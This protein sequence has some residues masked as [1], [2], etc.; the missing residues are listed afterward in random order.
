MA[1]Y[2]IYLL[3]AIF[4][5]IGSAN[6]VPIQIAKHPYF[7][8][9]AVGYS[10]GG[11]SIV[12]LSQSVDTELKS[13]V[14]SPNQVISLKWSSVQYEDILVLS[15][16]NVIKAIRFDNLDSFNPSAMISLRHSLPIS[17]VGW[18][19]FGGESI[20]VGTSFGFV[21]QYSFSFETTAGNA[22]YWIHPESD[23]VHRWFTGCKVNFVYQ[24]S[25]GS[26]IAGCEEGVVWFISATNA[27][28][29]S[30]IEFP[31]YSDYPSPKV[32][33]REARGYVVA[34]V[35]DVIYLIDVVN[36]ISVL[37]F[38]IQRKVGSST[39]TIGDSKILSMDV[40]FATDSE[41]DTL[42]I[43]TSDGVIIYDIEGLRSGIIP[44][45]VWHNSTSLADLETLGAEI[46]YISV[47][48]GDVTNTPSVTVNGTVLDVTACRNDK[49]L[50]A[51]NQEKSEITCGPDPPIVEIDIT[52]PFSVEYIE[53][54]L[55]L[56]SLG[57]IPA[58]DCT[59]LK[60]PITEWSKNQ[61]SQ[62]TRV[63]PSTRGQRN[64]AS[65][66]VISDTPVSD[67]LLTVDHCKAAC[68]LRPEC[69]MI[70]VRLSPDSGLLEVCSFHRCE[71]PEVAPMVST[72]FAEIWTLTTNMRIWND[73]RT[74]KIEEFGGYV[75]FGTD[76]SVLYGGCASED[77]LIPSDNSLAVTIPSSS[78]KLTNILRFQVSQNNAE[79]TVRISDLDLNIRVAYTP[80]ESFIEVPSSSP[81]GYYLADSSRTG[82]TYG[83]IA[84][85]GD[86]L[87][88]VSKSIVFIPT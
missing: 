51:M 55:S 52:L 28:P 38:K 68:E 75:A 84:F 49:A 34:L 15:D 63:M 14:I 30:S 25:S 10:E 78:V 67:K 26:I 36:E 43:R 73:K 13:L 42:F 76:Q 40:S 50:F 21:D 37:D 19:T 74:S 57:E 3:V 5:L 45:I 31:R 72:E 80:F 81:G 8:I 86:G 53:G 1:S 22:D 71:D 56:Q 29:M 83:P 58:M 60:A 24:P 65:C 70:F 69:N 88:V 46:R 27:L 9:A 66:P 18:D 4:C 64:D 41:L 11:V 59:S 85:T 33:F 6:A 7:P 32:I 79:A 62:W 39:F 87:L 2:E 44:S 16:D 61:A 35:D 23:R 12:D 82:S 47:R 48:T 54:S 77:G 20:V 17:A